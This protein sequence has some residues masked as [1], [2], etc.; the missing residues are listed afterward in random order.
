MYLLNHIRAEI[1]T[2]P[3][4]LG[5]FRTQPNFPPPPKFWLKTLHCAVL[6]KITDKD[7]DVASTQWYCQSGYLASFVMLSTSCCEVLGKIVLVPPCSSARAVCL[8]AG[9]AEQQPL[10]QARLSLHQAMPRA[11][12]QENKMF[13]VGEPQVLNR[14]HLVFHWYFYYKYGL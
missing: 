8:R 2:F 12:K 4:Y 13:Q 6:L 1:S 9:E 11:R 7:L 5:L 14:H 3:L 10:S